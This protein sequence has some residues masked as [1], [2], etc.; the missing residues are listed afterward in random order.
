MITEDEDKE[1]EKEHV[2]Q[3]LTKC[4]YPRWMLSMEVKPNT[5]ENVTHNERPESTKKCSIALPYIKGLS[6]ELCRI[7]RD[8]GCRTTH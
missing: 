3:A 8:Y 2:R 1:K 6:E 7:F 4:G 5:E